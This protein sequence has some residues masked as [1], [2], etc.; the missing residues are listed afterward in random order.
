MTI[1]PLPYKA[2]DPIGKRFLNLAEIGACKENGYEYKKMKAK[3]LQMQCFILQKFSPIKLL[4][5]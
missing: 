5:L 1:Q 2:S 4:T 3:N